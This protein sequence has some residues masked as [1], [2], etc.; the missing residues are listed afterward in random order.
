MKK[1]LSITRKLLTIKSLTALLAVIFFSLDNGGLLKA[2]DADYHFGIR[3]GVGMSTL[4][5]FE[6]NGLKLGITAGGYA[7]YMIDEY[8]S[9]NAELSYSTGG[10]QSEKWLEN[11]SEQLKVYSKYNLHYLNLP[12]LYQYYF[13]DILGV[14]GGVNFRY[15][16]T[17]SLKTKVGN[18][19]WQSVDFDQNYYNSFDLG[20]IFGVYTENLIPHDNFF[21]SLRSYFGFLDVVKNV[22]ANKN[23]SIQISV[24]YMFK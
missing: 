11:G 14:E 13:T 20:L 1:N 17:G 15:C 2:Q 9:I 10:Q 21:V 16:L 5:G 23:I 7:K 3:G 24:G 22:G 8:S 12:I 19:R 4:T 18:E 6:N